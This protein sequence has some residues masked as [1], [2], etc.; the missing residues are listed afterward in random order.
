VRATK[1][2]KDEETGK[3]GNSA[4]A[5]GQGP[6][7][8]CRSSI[9]DHLIGVGEAWWL[10]RSQAVCVI[11]C[12]KISNRCGVTPQSRCSWSKPQRGTCLP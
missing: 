3:V 8:F 5:L 9:L 7:N 2:A 1:I 4:E 11:D 6:V 12:R 10:R